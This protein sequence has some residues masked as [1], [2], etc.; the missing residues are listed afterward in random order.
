M[1]YTKCAKEILKEIGGEK[2]IKDLTHCVTRL[3]F[4][5]KD[6]SIVDDEKVKAIQ[7]VM[8]I[9]KKGGQYQVIIGNDVNTCYKAVLSQTSLGVGNNASTQEDKKEPLTVKSAVNRVLDVISGSMSAVMAPLIGCGMVKLL[10]IVLGLLG[11]KDTNMTY[12]LLVVI[13]DS[14]FYFLPVLLAYTSSKKFGANPMLAVVVSSVLIHPTLIQ[15]LGGEETV[16]FL[17]IK[18]TSASYA[19][20]VI[21]ALLATWFLS[22]VERIV[23]RFTPSWAKNIFKPM[24]ILLITIPVVLIVLA[25]AGNIIGNGLAVG[26]MWLQTKM[27]W[28]TLMIFSAIMPFVVMTGMHWAFIPTAITTLATG[29]EGM[30]LPAMLAS[31]LAQGSACLAVALK[32]KNKELKS[33]ATAGGISALV[34][35]ITEPGLYG[36]ALPL[37]KPM[38]ACC[39]GS[40]ISGLILG[41]F[42]V[43]SYGA[44][45]PSLISLLQF[46]SPEGGSNII[47]AVIASVVSIIVTFVL[48]WVLGFDDPVENDGNATVDGVTE[49]KLVFSPIKGKVISLKEVPDETFASEI[50]G[51][52]IAISPEEGKVFAPFDG[53]V[54]SVF[55]TLH[56]YGLRSDDGVE[57]L[58]HIGLE[59]VR[60]EGKGF[61]AHVKQGDK[62]SRG[63]LLVEMD[64]D[65][66]QKEGYEIVTPIVFS[67]SDQ[68]EIIEY[69]KNNEVTNMDILCCIS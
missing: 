45:V 54:V 28:L 11:V 53:E 35:G 66:I 43:L 30:L 19:S 2:N 51:K 29:G 33:V 39:I 1:D 20:S 55:D 25:P 42:G 62:I 7:G 40:G 65:L 6:E 26:M 57:V 8:G 34:A 64:L 37:K 69:T 9:M 36:V 41:I 47:Y 24:F 68:I 48:T 21:P 49:K 12:Q 44:A 16:T 14:C 22:Y 59:T 5:L 18:V 10:V 56:A 31:N 4:V 17:G 67:N 58:I 13:G 27:G 61:T 32:S 3:R 52:G 23:D 63:D 60:L 50:L 38:L 46:I 15:L